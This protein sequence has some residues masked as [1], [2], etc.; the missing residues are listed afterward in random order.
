[1]KSR[2]SMLLALLLSAVTLCGW[3][4]NP[5]SP[6]AVTLVKGAA[7]IDRF[8]PIPTTEVSSDCWGADA[9]RPRNMLN[10]IES[11]DYSYWGGKIIVG[12]DKKYHLFVCRWPQDISNP[13]GTKT[14]HK[15]WWNSDVVHA[16]SDIP[17]GP[18]K[19]VAEI[20]KGHNP[21]IYQLPDK[22]YVI[23]VM[24]PKAYI[25]S[26]LDG[27]WEEIET[28]FDFLESG[29]NMTNRTYIVED[30]FVYMMNKQG[31]GF[32]C[33]DG[34]ENFKQISNT[35]AYTRSNGSH[36]EDPV[37]WRD[38]IE[39]N[40]IVNE[41]IG[42]IAYHLTSRDG[43]EW[44]YEEGFAYTPEIVVNSNGIK[45][46]WWKLERPKVLTD[47]YGRVTHMNF[48][49]IDTLKACDVAN[50]RHSS[51]NIVVPMLL[52]SRMQ[53]LSPSRVTPKTTKI[54][55]KILAE[56][57]LNLDQIDLSTLRLGSSSLVNHG[58]GLRVARSKRV[59]D[60]LVLT[61]KGKN[62]GLTEADYK[63][64]LLGQLN[65]GTPIWARALLE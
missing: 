50:D 31:L 19:V 1:M 16:V 59:S 15:L 34:V 38:E 9:V 47:K 46:E 53:L 35:R 49:A 51:K 57:G 60:G 12:E 24:G 28:K 45:E 7:F 10:G 42:R 33:K 21:E 52:E 40:L 14:G 62:S 23:G 61:F 3:G 43:A 25:S 22:R 39:Y 26:S 18:Y 20:G 5:S 30:D 32:I 54:T 41:C 37:I 44:N 17:T 2:I 64:K 4:V 8:L 13:A 55:V 27:P 11:E 6:T 63:M 48:A 58:E 36:E 29:A 56:E 65:C